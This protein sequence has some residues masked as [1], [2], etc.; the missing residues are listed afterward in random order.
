MPKKKKIVHNVSVLIIINL[1]NPKYFIFLKRIQLLQISYKSKK[2]LLKYLYF[3]S[4][5]WV[6]GCSYVTTDRIGRNY[7]FTI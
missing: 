1:I 4:G 7:Y 2:L 6:G 5:C 3:V